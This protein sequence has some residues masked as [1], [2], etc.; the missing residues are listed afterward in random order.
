MR[1]HRAMPMIYICQLLH[2]FQLSVE[3]KESG[4]RTTE[5]LTGL[6]SQHKENLFV[7]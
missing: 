1:E 7:K 2:R 6:P 4:H 5:G 3:T